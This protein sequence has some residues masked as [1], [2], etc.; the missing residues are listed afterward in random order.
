MSK[1]KL[2]KALSIIAGILPIVSIIRNILIVTADD[3]EKYIDALNKE[4]EIG[5]ME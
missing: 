1:V 4:E 5:K 2:V 3:I